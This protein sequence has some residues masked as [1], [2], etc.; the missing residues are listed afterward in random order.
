MKALYLIV[1]KN[2]VTLLFPQFDMPSILEIKLVKAV[3]LFLPWVCRASDLLPCL[4]L[5][6]LRLLWHQKH[7]WAEHLLGLLLCIHWNSLGST[8]RSPEHDWLPETKCTHYYTCVLNTFLNTHNVGSSVWY[9]YITKWTH[10]N[11]QDNKVDD[12]LLIK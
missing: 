11:I 2:R 7:R 9:M 8:A 6:T 10:W 12:W 5:G 3:Y 4:W 1:F